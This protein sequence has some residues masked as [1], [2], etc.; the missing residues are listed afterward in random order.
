MDHRVSN[1]LEAI[2]RTLWPLQ[3]TTSAWVTMPKQKYSY[4]WARLSAL[5]KSAETRALMSNP[6]SLPVL[7]GSPLHQLLAKVRTILPCKEDVSAVI[8]YAA[9][10]QAL[11]CE[12]LLHLGRLVHWLQQTPCMEL[13]SLPTQHS[14]LL[15]MDWF[16]L[17]AF[18]EDLTRNIMVGAASPVKIDRVVMCACQEQLL[19]TSRFARLARPEPEH[20]TSSYPYIKA[21]WQS[22]I[23][24]VL[25]PCCLLLRG[26]KL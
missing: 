11:D 17:L 23:E 21:S 2:L 10:K 14:D 19:S 13:H 4:D 15:K 26:R 6:P 18:L 9:A 3:A 5:L 12:A 20:W 1:V 7:K 16:Y 25:K 8:D 24:A 22:C